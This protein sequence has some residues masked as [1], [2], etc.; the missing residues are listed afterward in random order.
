M[1][2]ST[3]YDRLVFHAKN[4]IPPDLERSFD[5][6]VSDVM[7]QGWGGRHSN[8]QISHELTS[9]AMSRIWLKVRD[10]ED[11]IDEVEIDSRYKNVVR[12]EISTEPDMLNG[13]GG[14][15][16]RGGD[17]HGDGDDG[18]DILRW[19][20]VAHR[21]GNAVIRLAKM[22]RLQSLVLDMH[23]TYFAYDEVK[24]YKANCEK[25]FLEVISG[26][27]TMIPAI[28]IHGLDGKSRY[29]CCQD[30]ET[31]DL[32]YVPLHAALNSSAQLEYRASGDF[33]KSI[34]RC[35]NG[36]D[37]EPRHWDDITPACRCSECMWEELGLSG[38]EG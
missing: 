33:L 12:L 36:A 13:N 14:F 17:I 8:N 24:Y 7:G 20:Q 27:D 2:S 1:S 4:S 3:G 22:L 32:R 29:R 16:T 28:W 31:D 37:L 35:A 10:I 9:Y 15:G 38:Y 18:L 21:T 5:R 11:F 26:L 19:E 6:I 30:E 23:G 34:Y 25:I